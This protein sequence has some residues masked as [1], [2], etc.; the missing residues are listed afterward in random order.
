[1]A[2]RIELRD[3]TAGN[4]RAVAGVEPADDQLAL[5]APVTRYLC[6]CHYGGV[7]RPL[8]VCSGDETVGFVMWAIDPDDRSG[9]IG[10]LVID[11]RRQREGLGRATVLAL[12]ARLA[13]DGCDSVALSYAPRNAAARALYLSLG[14]EETGEMEDDEVVARLRRPA[15]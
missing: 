9:W 13:A 3:V 11:R 15:L 5:V 7:W 1:M 8:A 2:P 4:W 6:L 10:G 14:F 12:V